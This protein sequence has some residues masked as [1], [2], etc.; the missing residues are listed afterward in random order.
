MN[1][2]IKVSSLQ[3]EMS[4]IVILDAQNWDSTK[5]YKQKVVKQKEDTY[6]QKK[7]NEEERKHNIS[8]SGGP[9]LGGQGAHRGGDL[10]AHPVGLPA[11]EGVRRKRKQ[12]YRY[13]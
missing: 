3:T 5:Q 4:N 2:E 7:E 13:K 1:N 11:A 6:K 9:G 10:H 12:Y 8:C